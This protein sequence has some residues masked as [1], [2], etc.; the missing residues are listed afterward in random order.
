MD[1]WL[2]DAE[3]STLGEIGNRLGRKALADVATVAKPDTILAWYPSWSPTGS[4]ARKLVAAQAG[5]G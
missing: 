3:R 2:S 4:M 5:P 1:A